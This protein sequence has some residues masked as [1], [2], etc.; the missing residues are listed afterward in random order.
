MAAGQGTVPFFT[1]GRSDV[2]EQ[3]ILE[4][5]ADLSVVE[6]VRARQAFH[7][8]LTTYIKK[9]NSE[10]DSAIV[11]DAIN[12]AIEASLNSPP[13]SSE[14]A[15]STEGGK[16]YKGGAGVRDELNRLTDTFITRIRRRLRTA[17]SDAAASIRVANT[18]GEEL[19]DAAAIVGRVSTF[20]AVA[21]IATYYLIPGAAE[22]I[23]SPEWSQI[24]ASILGLI[25]TLVVDLPVAVADAAVN[26]PVIALAMATAIMKYRASQQRISLGDLIKNDAKRLIVEPAKEGYRRARNAIR[27]ATAPSATLAG[28]ARTLRYQASRQVYPG[29]GLQS[30]S[31]AEVDALPTGEAGPVL[32]VL[33][34]LRV[35]G[36]YSPTGQVK[37]AREALRP[38]LYPGGVYGTE[39]AGAITRKAHKE[40]LEQVAREAAQA[41]AAAAAALSPSSSSSSSS[42]SSAAAAAAGQGSNAAAAGQ[43]APAAMAQEEEESPPSNAAGAP[44]SSS[45]GPY[46]LRPR[47]G[48]ATCGGRRRPLFAP[49]R[50]VRRSS[51][52]LKKR[53]TRRRRALRF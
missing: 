33:R 13:L 4:G 51:S 15:M 25:K 47:N 50:K 45:S 26:N 16:R 10:E 46:N 30:G 3:N 29:M 39:R 32:P 8:V 17:E 6:V 48:G 52:S 40:I 21:S 41:E 11:N 42:S 1:P 36:A 44:S 35:V 5:Q 22:Y 37:S 38:I 12:D 49:T 18:I 43:S 34:E 14:T 20:G 53:Y 27:R 31:V 23:P 19:I 7:H 2:G 28:V 24:G 9:D